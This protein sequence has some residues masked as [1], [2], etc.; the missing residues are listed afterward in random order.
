METIQQFLHMF[1][2]FIDVILHL[3]VHLNVWVT[4]FGPWIYLILFAIIFCETG[5]IVTPF[6][7]GDS[8]LFALGAL[9]ATDNAYLDLKL[10]A[11]V[12]ITAGILGDAVN[13]SI[14]RYFGVKVFKIESRFL[15]KEYL[16]KTQAFY[17]KHGGKTIILARYVPI[18]RTFA[19]FV[20]GVGEMK[21]SRFFAYNVVGAV[22]WVLI[23][24]LLG[25]YFGN[26]PSVKSN[27]HIVIFAI[28]GISVL[29]MI[30]EIVRNY[31]QNP[32]KQN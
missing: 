16:E 18:I 11:V 1:L 27:F 19:P 32:S 28:I 29:P 7:P 3:D 14:G 20:A 10:L 4:N 17:E 22:T 6:L 13:Y 9:A 2:Q 15:K 12:L 8:L 31:R 5:L 25:N 24:L 21:Y 23:F 26:L 30:I